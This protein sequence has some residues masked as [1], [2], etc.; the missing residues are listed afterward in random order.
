MVSSV[1][2]Y[3]D[4]FSPGVITFKGSQGTLTVPIVTATSLSITSDVNATSTQ[5]GALVVGGGVG[6]GSDIWFNG[7]IMPMKMEIF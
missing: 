3:L 7:K 2:R 5:T 1:G 4:A 6:I